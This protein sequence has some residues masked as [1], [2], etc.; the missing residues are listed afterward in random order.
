[1]PAA[2]DLSGRTAVV[3]GASSGIGRAIALAL[4]RAGAHVFLAG[5]SQAPMDETRKEIRE[6]GGQAD[7]VVLDVR[8]VEALRGLVERAVQDTGRLDVMVNNAG[9]SYPGD[10]ADADPEH[11][12]EM[13]EVNVLSLLV[14]SQAAIRAMRAAGNGG[15]LVNISSIAA[16]R[17]DSGVYGATKHAV[18]CI[19]ASLRLELEDDDIR[20]VTI[21]PGAIAT[22]FAR[23]FDPAFLKG[24]AATAGVADFEPQAGEKLPD[25]VLDRIQPIMEKL[26]SK[27][28]DVADTVL[29]AI[30]L[31]QT[32]N[33]E[34][35]VVRPAKALAL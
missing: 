19:S 30:S 3:T 17:R 6:A 24:L 7:A 35:L 18:N 11:W 14:G 20:V 21:M 26:L 27:P 15:H 2:P 10:I 31:P 22:N 28:E 9:L 34:E 13:L 29:Y 5:R 12:R 33:I 23:N 32:V 25:E 1:M 8:D 4:G 16:H